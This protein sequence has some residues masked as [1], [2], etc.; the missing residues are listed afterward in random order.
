M[1]ARRWRCKVGR[2]VLIPLHRRI[3]KV[4]FLGCFN[5][6]A[7]ASARLISCDPHTVCWGGSVAVNLHP[8]SVLIDVQNVFQEQINLEKHNSVILCEEHQNKI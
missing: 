4:W 3:T 1:V 7:E 2:K 5:A 6:K 8:G